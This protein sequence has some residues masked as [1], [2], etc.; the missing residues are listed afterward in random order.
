[1]VVW[2]TTPRPGLEGGW[3]LGGGLLSVRLGPEASWVGK[4]LGK[5]IWMVKA[6]SWM[7]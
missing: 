1:M 5:E 2:V 4:D 3:P 7:W 6:G